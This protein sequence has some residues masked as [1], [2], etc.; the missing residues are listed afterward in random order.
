MQN[1][2]KGDGIKDSP[3][4]MLLVI[5]LEGASKE[6]VTPSLVGNLSVSTNLWLTTLL[7]LSQSNATKHGWPSIK[8]LVSVPPFPSSLSLLHFPFLQFPFLLHFIFVLFLLSPSAYV[9]PSW[10]VLVS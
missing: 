2:D 5:L 9:D 1:K 4:D 8:H 6:V 3:L 10:L 7:S